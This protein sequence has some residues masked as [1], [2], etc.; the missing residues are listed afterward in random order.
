[1]YTAL[2][3]LL[4]DL[5]SPVWQGVLSGQM[6]SK[7]AIAAWDPS[8]QHALASPTAPQDCFNSVCT[9]PTVGG[10]SSSSPFGSLGLL[11]GLLIIC[12][13]AV[14]LIALA[15]VGCVV[16]R[17]R[18]TAASALNR[19]HTTSEIGSSQL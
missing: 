5:D 2:L 15:V 8:G 10:S 12:G 18:A 19:L 3:P 13:G 17:K 16:Y 11:G 4:I 14:V 7:V 6:D 9:V 1:V